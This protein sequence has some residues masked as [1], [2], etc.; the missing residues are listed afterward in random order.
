MSAVVSC[1]DAPS[2][3]TQ[4][5]FQSALIAFLF[6]SHCN[7][8][9]RQRSWANG[10][11]PTKV[12][13][14]HVHTL[15]RSFI[16]KHSFPFNF[17]N[18][19][20]SERTCITCSTRPYTDTRSPGKTQKVKSSEVTTTCRLDCGCLR[21]QQQRTWHTWTPCRNNVTTHLIG[22]SNCRESLRTSHTAIWLCEASSGSSEKKS[23][24]SE[25][26]ISACL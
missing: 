14:L 3:I 4:K 23:V 19:P 1:V 21:H 7:L 13:I 5:V 26:K 18:I 22:A 24:R 8:A 11:L 17:Q 15:K 10:E 2:M 6:R 20:N 12:V 16:T 25:S 9:Q